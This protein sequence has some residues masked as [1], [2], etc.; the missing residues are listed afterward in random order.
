MAKKNLLFE[1]GLE[2]LPAKNLNI[3]SEKIKKNIENNFLKN[4]ITF[5]SIDNFYTNLRLVFFVNDIEENIIKQKKEIK[6]PPYDNCFDENGL[7]NKVGLGFAKKYNTEINSLYKK[8][9]DNRNYLFY[10]QPERISKIKEILPSI[11]E[12]SLESIEDQK[13]MRWGDSEVYF[14]RPIRWM[15]L[16]LND[17]II[18]SEI[19]GIKS[20]NITYG[21][22]CLSCNP[23]KVKNTSEYFSK[24]KEKGVEIDQGI[25]KKIIQTD[26]ENI[27][28]KN[29]FDN[30]I[31][32]NLIDELTNMIEYPYIYLGK[33]PEKYLDLPNKVLKYVIQDTQKYSLVQKNKK[34]I[35]YFVGISNIEINQSIVKGN[36]RVINPRL[37]DAK[38]FI[39]KDLQDNIFGKKDFLKRIVFHKKLGSMF[40]KVQRI[41]E[42][43]SYIN[44]Q[45]YRDNKLKFKEIADLCKLDLISNMV[46]EIPKLQ[47]YIG[48]FYAEKSN[49]DEVVANGIKEHYSPK[50]P[51]DDIPKSVDAQ[52]VSMADKIDT[53]V[54]IFLVNEKP[55]GTRDPLAIRRS[56]NGLLRVLLGTD[57]S[58]S[59]TKLVD[60]TYKV[61]SCKFTNLR[62]NKEALTDCHIFL[63]DKLITLFEEDYRFHSDLISSV[64]NNGTD[65]NPFKALKKITAL[66]SIIENKDYEQLF[67][68]AKRVSNILKKSKVDSQVSIDENLLK[69]SSEKFL[70][71]SFKEN[72]E[73]LKSLFENGLYKE[74][75]KE[76]NELNSYVVKFFD[77]V[78]IND[79]KEEIKLNRISLLTLINKS[80]ISLANLAILSR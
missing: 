59:L 45:S 67:L 10:E 79:N 32:S 49:F 6:G 18:F 46:V 7:P 53:I 68:N 72:E 17:E 9:I 40:D 11:L 62:N 65:I 52:I 43:S 34:I 77:E 44:T 66:D 14:I 12:D 42:I 64:I 21:N 38:F 2:D 73:N 1:I 26:I 41:S 36:E 76:I 60:A 47:G 30:E 33:F 61:I 80:Y 22:K 50:N 70:Y 63:K 19:L 55:S 69:E 24:I 5:R 15:L 13:K 58:I 20:G 31:D 71:S 54:G 56:T 51:E 28:K 37:D 4:Q 23:I 29:K 16:V 78:M 8:R 35:N 25:R 48:S 27:I 75:L 74:Y 39:S 3:F 57:H